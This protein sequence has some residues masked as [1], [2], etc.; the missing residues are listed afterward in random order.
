MDTYV[1]EVNPVEHDIADDNQFDLLDE[2]VI[3]ELEVRLEMQGGCIT[4]CVEW[5]WLGNCTIG[6]SICP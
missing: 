6:Q 3:E 2:M 1:T 5:D 4:R